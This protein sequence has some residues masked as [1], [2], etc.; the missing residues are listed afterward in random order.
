MLRND[1]LDEVLAFLFFDFVAAEVFLGLGEYNVFAQNGVVFA[2]SEFV[3]G[4]H[5]VFA[6][7][8]LADARAFRD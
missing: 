3:G 6:G 1:W 7:V 4:I 8:I 5:G 2:E